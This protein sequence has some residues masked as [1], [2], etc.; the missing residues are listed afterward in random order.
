M[1]VYILCEEKYRLCKLINARLNVT[2]CNIQLQ[3]LY[4]EDHTFIEIKKIH[5]LIQ[6]ICYFYSWGKKPIVIKFIIFSHSTFL[7]YVQ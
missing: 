6:N 2:L 1:Y 5:P 4:A 7:K 3:N